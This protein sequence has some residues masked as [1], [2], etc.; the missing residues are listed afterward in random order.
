MH[1]CNNFSNDFAMF[2]VGKGIPGH[3]TSLPQDV[4]NTPF[5]Q[6]LRPQLDA[7]M[8]PIT[9]A[10]TPQPVKPAAS[11]RSQPTTSATNGTAKTATATNGNTLAAETGRVHNVTT[12]KEVD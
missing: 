7:M 11:A 2:L 5:G 12:I 1:N 4:L 10:P 3:I 9:Q 6:M 8:R